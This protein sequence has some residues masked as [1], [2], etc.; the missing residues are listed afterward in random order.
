MMMTLVAPLPAV[1]LGQLDAAAFHPIDGADVDAVRADH[2]HVLGD[3]VR[4]HL[5]SPCGFTAMRPLPEVAEQMLRTG[6]PW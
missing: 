5:A 6:F 4:G 1:F 3:L 2:F